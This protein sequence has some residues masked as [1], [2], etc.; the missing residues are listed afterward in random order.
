MICVV[1]T[2]SSI[3]KKGGTR[4]SDESVLCFV[5]EVRNDNKVSEDKKKVRN[6]DLNVKQDGMP[7]G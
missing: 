2:R 3:K 6:S 4:V 5:L 7:G 1:L